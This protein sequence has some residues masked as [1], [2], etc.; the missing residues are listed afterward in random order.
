MS[1]IRLPSA[2]QET[3]HRS[4]ALIY[5]AIREGLFSH[6][7]AIG[8]RARGWPDYEVEVINAARIAGKSDAEIRE[9]VKTLPPNRTNPA[10]AL[11]TV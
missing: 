5:N 10:N 6:G 8:Q 3:G 2:K 4:N 1:I 7:V 11:P 9:P